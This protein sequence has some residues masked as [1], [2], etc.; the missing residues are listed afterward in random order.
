MIYNLPRKKKA[1]IQV[2]GMN[3][4]E[5]TIVSQIKSLKVELYAG[6]LE[7]SDALEILGEEDTEWLE[8]STHFIPTGIGGEYIFTFDQNNDALNTILEALNLQ[9]EE[10][11]YEN[12]DCAIVCL[13]IVDAYD[14]TAVYLM[15][16]A[17]SDIIFEEN[18]DYPYF[19]VIKGEEQSNG[20]YEE[21]IVFTDVVNRGDANG[22][23][24]ITISEINVDNSF[25]L[26]VIYPKQ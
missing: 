5:S 13:S 14:P 11:L 15:T 24:N 17:I 7:D 22:Y 2:V 3:A 18:V 23:M 1:A 4:F 12:Y 8:N 21:S 26:V 25:Y 10:D 20:K 19:F 9:N 16:A 6:T